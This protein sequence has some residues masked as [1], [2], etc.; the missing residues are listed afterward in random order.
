LAYTFQAAEDLPLDL[1]RHAQAGVE[2]VL[3][4]P[5]PVQRV[6]EDLE[7]PPLAVGPLE[8]AGVPQH[9]GHL[10]RHV[11][12][13]LELAPGE[14]LLRLPPREVEGARH[15]VVQQEREHEPRLVTKGPEQLEVEAGV[16]V[17]V[18]GEDGLTGLPDLLAEALFPERDRV[19]QERLHHLLRDVVAG[20]GHEPAARLVEQ[21]GRAGVGTH[22]EHQLATDPAQRLLHVEGGARG[23]GDGEHDLHLAQPARGLGLQVHVLAHQAPAPHHPLHDGGEPRHLERLL[24]VAG[25]AALHRLHRRAHGG[26]AGDDD[27]L[28]GIRRAL[29]RV[30]HLDA[31]HIGQA[32]VDEQQ[33]HRAFA[34]PGEPVTPGVGEDDRVAFPREVLAHGRGDITIVV[35]DEDGFGIHAENSSTYVSPARESD[36]LVFPRPGAPATGGLEQQSSQELTET[37][38]TKS[39]RRVRP[40]PGPVGAST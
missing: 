6:E 19:A 14:H 38:S 25:G 3:A 9:H 35:D 28:G 22:Q 17:H 31:V 18:V 2:A 12:G 4:G 32:Q 23:A 16:R 21:V 30:H 13:Q 40:S 36:L 15:R 34:E 24:E 1:Q 29:G 5:L 10:G 11:L 27:D 33:R 37:R 39:R 7:L 26:V 8:E 20:G